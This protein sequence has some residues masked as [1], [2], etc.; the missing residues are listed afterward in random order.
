[1]HKLVRE[2]AALL[3]L[4]SQRFC[5]S[6]AWWRMRFA[7]TGGISGLAVFEAELYIRVR[8][9]DELGQRDGVYRR[10]WF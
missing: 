4:H 5:G 10:T 7:R 2:Q 6:S 8:R 3:E 1:M 9:V